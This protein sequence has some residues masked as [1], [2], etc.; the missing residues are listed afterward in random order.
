MYIATKYIGTDFTP[1]EVL[2]DG[3]DEALIQ[4]LLKTG[5]IRETAPDPSPAAVRDV[6]TA[7]EKAE[8]AREDEE[9]E[10][11]EADEEADE[12]EPEPPEVDVS[13][14]LVD[15]SEDKPKTS[16]SKKGGSRK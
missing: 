1:G 11:E 6:P 15:N 13:A 5:A 2:P 16:R 7:E 14:A 3:L 4:R 12:Q 8:P 10:L 9:T